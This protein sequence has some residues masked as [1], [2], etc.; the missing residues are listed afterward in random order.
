MSQLSQRAFSPPWGHRW[1]PLKLWLLNLTKRT[2]LELRRFSHNSNF[3]FRSTG[4]RFMQTLGH[5]AIGVVGIQVASEMSTIFA[6]LLIW[7]KTDWT[8]PTS[9]C[10]KK[11]ILNNVKINVQDGPSYAIKSLKECYGNE[12]S[13]FYKKSENCWESGGTD[14]QGQ[15]ALCWQNWHSNFFTFAHTFILWL[16]NYYFI[17]RIS[18]ICNI[19]SS[20]FDE[21]VSFAFLFLKHHKYI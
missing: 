14:N 6:S 3:K 1:L 8:Q 10:Q 2:N 4:E 20:I 11:S 7:V 13:G 12:G 5:K 18:G 15:K 21:I 16:V 19:L 9:F 17:G